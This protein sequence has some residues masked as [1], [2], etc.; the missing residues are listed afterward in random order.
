[1]VRA[2]KTP[3]S[4]GA[5]C[6]RDRDRARLVA[7]TD[8][9]AERGSPL[10]M[11]MSWMGPW[12]GK[13]NAV[14]ID[15]LTS[16]VVDMAENVFV[17]GSAGRVSV[18]FPPDRNPKPKQAFDEEIDAVD[19]VNRSGDFMDLRSVGTHL[20][21]CGMARQV[22]RR[23]GNRKWARVDRGTVLPPG[24]M[25]IKG[26]TSMDGVSEDDFYAVGF[27]GETWRCRSGAWSQMES[28]TDVILQCVRVLAPDRMY[29]CG[30]SGVLLRGDGQRWQVLDPSVKGDDELW[31]IQGFKG[32][33]Y[34]ASTS[35]IYKLDKN[36]KLRKV[37]T[38]LGKNLTHM[39]LHAADGFLWSFGVKDVMLTQDGKTWRD[40]T[41]GS[42]QYR[43]R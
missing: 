17:M 1:M 11:M 38:K 42:K 35:A 7:S 12:P 8:V 26:F 27:D 40:A 29:A 24:S 4:F 16:R 36:D 6:V 10:T 41:P 37:D 39:H 15:W 5:G 2:S 28:V 32:E 34:V 14:D 3:F 13:W 20:Y 23:E 19:G 33:V 9:L 18:R 43:P 31:S 21:A 25:D 30:Q 22:Y